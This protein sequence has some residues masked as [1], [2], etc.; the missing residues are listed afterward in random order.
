MLDYPYIMFD[1]GDTIMKDD[2]SLDIPMMQWPQVE[3]IEGAEEVLR[4]L[5]TH[6]T[7]VM[8]TSADRSSEDEIRAALRRVDLEAYFDHIFCF[9]KTG[10]QKSSRDFYLYILE[11][12][13]IQPADILMVGDHFEKDVQLA[14]S[15]GIAAIWLNMKDTEDRQG[16]QFQTI[17]RLTDLLFLL[18]ETV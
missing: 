13:K 14:N 5:H 3:A 15:A 9:K 18:E 7:I 11:A 17:H 10:L 2:P 1:W 6:R 4:A 12:L 16:A 8:A